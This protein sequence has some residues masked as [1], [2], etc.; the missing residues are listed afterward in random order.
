[1]KSE[2][3]PRL[4]EFKLF[5]K[6]GNRKGWHWVGTAYFKTHKEAYQW[7]LNAMHYYLGS[8]DCKI[9]SFQDLPQKSASL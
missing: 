8:I 9:R 4:K 3:V 6:Y 7:G 2:P 5:M 1:M